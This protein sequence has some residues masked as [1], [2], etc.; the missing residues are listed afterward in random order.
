LLRSNLSYKSISLINELVSSDMKKE[1]AVR[2]IEILL[3]L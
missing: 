3:K 2:A 1:R